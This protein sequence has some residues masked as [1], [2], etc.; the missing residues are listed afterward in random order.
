M[1]DTVSTAMAGIT[2]AAIVAGLSASAALAQATPPAPAAEPPQTP[3]TAAPASED[4]NAVSRSATRVYMVDVNSIKTSGDAATIN[5]ARIPLNAP[6]AADRS[7][8]IVEMEFRCSAKQ[9]R[10]LAEIDHDETGKALDRFEMGEEFGPYAA[11]TL[12][13]FVAAVVCESARAE[14]PTFA[15]VAAF[16]DAGRPSPRR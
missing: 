5:L 8:T 6:N 2:L 7:Y 10:A 16:I 13:G 3:T 14:P 12:D 11:D 9:S 15:S 4:W 1:R